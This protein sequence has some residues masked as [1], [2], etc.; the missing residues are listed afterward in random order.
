MI[1]HYRDYQNQRQISRRSG[2]GKAAL[3]GVMSAEWLMTHG[4]HI[5]EIVE[6]NL[7]YYHY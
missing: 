2:R 4:A 3:G 5:S 1:N 7:K 6:A